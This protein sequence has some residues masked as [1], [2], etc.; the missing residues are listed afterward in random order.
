[1]NDTKPLV[2]YSAIE[3]RTPPT[4]GMHWDLRVSNYQWAHHKGVRC[5]DCSLTL[6]MHKL[7]ECKDRL[8]GKVE[9]NKTR[10]INSFLPAI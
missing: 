4:A 5:T 2:F 10:W 3:T 6:Q 7:N 8:I 1:M 9:E